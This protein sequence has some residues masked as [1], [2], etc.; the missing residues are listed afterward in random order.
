MSGMQKAFNAV[1]SHL[2]AQGAPAKGGEG[3][4]PCCYLSKIDG[5]KCAIGGLIPDNLLT[6]RLI[7]TVESLLHFYPEIKSHFLNEYGALP[8]HFYGEVQQIHDSFEPDQWEERFVK[9]A[10]KWALEVP[11]K[12]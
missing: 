2:R 9:F 1:V 5:K 3:Q 7:G 11:A 4:S 12:S 8:N 6:T 10:I